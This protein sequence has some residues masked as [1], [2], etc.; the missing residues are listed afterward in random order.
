[1]G[2]VVDDVAVVVVAADLVI[3]LYMLVMF[4]FQLFFD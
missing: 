3:R 1:M 4:S 2:N